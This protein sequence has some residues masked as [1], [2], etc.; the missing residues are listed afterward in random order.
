MYY[1]KTLNQIKKSLLKKYPD[2]KPTKN[3]DNIPGYILWMIERIENMGK[4]KSDSFR[5]AR[6]LGWILRVVEEDLELW[7]NLI[8]RKLVRKDIENGFE[9]F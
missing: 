8:S 3:I 1:P 2:A 6:W 7:D 5:A 9:S 4:S